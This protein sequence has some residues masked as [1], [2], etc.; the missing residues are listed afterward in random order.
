MVEVMQHTR[1]FD[2]KQHL[3]AKPLV[4]IGKY[5]LTRVDA[6]SDKEIPASLAVKVAKAIVGLGEI[7]RQKSQKTFDALKGA[8]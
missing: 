4:A 8:V 3:A 5:Y 2:P 6:S 1:G 7:G